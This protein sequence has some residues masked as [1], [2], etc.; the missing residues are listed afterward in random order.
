MQGVFPAV[1]RLVMLLVVVLVTLLP[2]VAAA[3]QATPGD[4][5]SDMYPRSV[6]YDLAAMI[7]QAEE[8]PVD[9]LALM[10]GRLLSLEQQ[11]ILLSDSLGL[12]PGEIIDQ[13][14]ELR[15]RG[16][17][18]A[19]FGIPSASGPDSVSVNAQS[20]VTEFR[21]EEGASGGF[22]LVENET[23]GSEDIDAPA[24]G[25]ES[26]LTRSEG[27]APD[28]GVPYERL[29]YTFRSGEFV[30]GITI[31]WFEG[32]ESAPVSPEEMA[33]SAE[34]ML[35]RIDSVAEEDRGLFGKMLR[36]ESGQEFAVADADEYYLVLDDH[37]PVLYGETEETAAH[38][39]QRWEGA[40]V[41][42]YYYGY[43]YVTPEGGDPDSG[44]IIVL[45]V[46]E[47]GSARE[48][49]AFADAEAE[50]MVVEGADEG[51]SS[52]EPLET[53]GVNAGVSYTWPLGDGLE[54]Q[55]YRLWVQEGPYVINIE[56][57]HPDGIDLDTLNGV[58][59][60]QVDCVT[61]DRF[62]RPIEIPEGLAG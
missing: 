11:A 25:D 36:F 33:A 46:Y 50:R 23:D 16:I 60:E 4:T 53:D 39:M 26:E 30:G 42:E 13:L 40:G 14:D 47:L 6:S 41:V 15:W 19:E 8:F 51:Y 49:R 5:P 55:G 31:H 54:T 12:P 10:R 3:R 7:L 1:M 21:N 52:V 58:L 34:I 44:A 32:A 59:S 57:D 20:Y 29:D 48:A 22:A 28:S 56:S 43:T 24:V 38:Y 9:G 45:R 18:G 37:M 27:V 17:Y 62:C 2:G 35:D 61:S